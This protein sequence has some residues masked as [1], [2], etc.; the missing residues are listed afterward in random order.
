MTLSSSGPSGAKNFDVAPRSLMN[1]CIPFINYTINPQYVFLP[2]SQQTTPHTN[3]E[4]AENYSFVLLFFHCV[5]SRKVAGS[6]P[7][8][9]IGIFH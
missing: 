2:Y 6:I 7:D 4:E 3:T 8:G 9:V 1:F 5:T